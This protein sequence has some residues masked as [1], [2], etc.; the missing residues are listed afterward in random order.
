[1]KTRG[2]VE[3]LLH[4]FLISE[5]DE[6]ALSVLRHSRFASLKRALGTHWLTAL[7]DTTFGLNTVGK[8][9]RSFLCQQLHHRI[10]KGEY[11]QIIFAM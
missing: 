8:T 5:T 6:H 10:R 11:D 1:M 7:M 4:A 2:K 3:V 9:E